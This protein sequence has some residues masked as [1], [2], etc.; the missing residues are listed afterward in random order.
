VPTRVLYL[1]GLGH[2]GTSLIGRVL[3]EVPGIVAL[4]E[5]VHLWQRGIRQDECCVCGSRFRACE[6]W[7]EVGTRAFGGWDR[8]DVHRI[9]AL[10][11]MVERA[12]HVPLLVAAWRGDFAALVA[13]Y[14]GYYARLYAAAA[15]VAGAR[16][17]VDSSKHSALALC[18]RHCAEIDLRILHVVRDPRGV[19][20]S[21]TKA[22]AETGES[23]ESTW[24]TPARSAVLWNAHNAAFGLLGQ[25]GTAVLRLRYEDFVADPGTAIHRVA[26]FADLDTSTLA[27]DFLRGRT[28]H[29]GQCHSAAGQP[30]RFTA[31]PLELRADEAWRRA[32]P[33][34][35]RALVGAVCAPLLHAYGYPLTTAGTAPLVRPG[36]RITGR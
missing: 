35:Q 4:G 3:G 30:A 8:V 1:G 5:V 19:A 13:E 32:L 33:P 36:Q 25:R 17:V 18:L 14:A 22:G 16:V 15:G 24:H 26:T 7:T 27:L 34:R 10:R 20:H 9:L 31:G 23:A 12:K 29:L 21:L 11:E 2:S 6:F 28:V